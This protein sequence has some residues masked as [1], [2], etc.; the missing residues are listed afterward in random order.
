MGSLVARSMDRCD[1]PSLDIR[2][3]K[4][5]LFFASPSVLL[6]S[7]L[8]SVEVEQEPRSLAIIAGAAAERPAGG[9]HG[10]HP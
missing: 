1:L 10:D 4:K 3:W 6:R 8:A 7:L 9:V 5:P 2:T